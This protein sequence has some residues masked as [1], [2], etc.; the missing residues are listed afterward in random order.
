MDQP[1]GDTVRVIF[2]EREERTEKMDFQELQGQKWETDV[3]RPSEI[4]RA[5]YGPPDQNP[6]Q[7]QEFERQINEIAAT[8]GAIRSHKFDERLDP[9]RDKIR[10]AKSTDAFI[11]DTEW[12]NDVTIRTVEYVIA[13]GAGAGLLKLTRDA[14]LQWLK[15]KGG[16]IVR[17]KRGDLS[18]EVKGDG[19]IERAIAAM[20][21]IPSSSVKRK[22][23]TK[24]RT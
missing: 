3:F 6:V 10:N 18:I 7:S 13:T 23:K 11:F 17:I 22:T 20:K 24:K 19:D 12:L 16:R 4:A 14:I 1:D 2:E 15:N 9:H 21:T 8:Q 5:T